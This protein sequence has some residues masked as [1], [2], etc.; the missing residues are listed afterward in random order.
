MADSSWLMRHLASV[1]GIEGVESVVAA[2]AHELGL[3]ARLEEV[4]SAVSK[5][6]IYE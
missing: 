2:S 4:L 5:A 6:L 1:G 3:E